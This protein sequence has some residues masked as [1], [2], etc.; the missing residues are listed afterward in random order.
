MIENILESLVKNAVITEDTGSDQESN[1]SSSKLLEIDYTME[2]DLEQIRHKF[3]DDHYKTW[4]NIPIPA[5]S[6]KAPRDAIKTK[7]GR[8]KVINLIKDMIN[9]EIRA[10]KRDPKRVFSNIGT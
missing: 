10:N 4:P 1:V 9:M 5:L 3:L 6:N 2:L 7:S 8:S